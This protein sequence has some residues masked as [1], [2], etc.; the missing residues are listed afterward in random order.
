MPADDFGAVLY[1]IT[2]RHSIMP[3]HPRVT[4]APDILAGKPVIR[5]TRLSVEF[6]IGL[7]AEGWNEAVILENYPGLS[8]EDIIACLAMRAIF[9]AR[10]RCFRAQPEHVKAGTEMHT[11]EN[12]GYRNVHKITGAPHLTVNHGAGEY[13]K[14]DIHVNTA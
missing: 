7:M 12:P 8:H 1:E 5:G 3:E 4:L 14:E 11:D 9:W 6:V 10:R 13:A 2:G